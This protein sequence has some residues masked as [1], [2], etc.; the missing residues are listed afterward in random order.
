[1]MVAKGGLSLRAIAQVA[2]VVRVVEEGVRA[3]HVCR[4]SPGV[5]Q[6]QF[7]LMPWLLHLVTF[8]SLQDRDA[9][10]TQVNTT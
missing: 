10:G 3:S 5:E 9:S 7:R 8:L 1:M 4:S 6:L 2:V